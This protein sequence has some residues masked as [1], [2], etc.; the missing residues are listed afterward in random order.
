MALS[1]A[2]ARLKADREIVMGA[3]KQNG[4]ALSYASADLKGDRE[5]VMDAVQQDGR[6]LEYVSADFKGDREIV[7]EAVKHAGWILDYASANLK[8][9]REIV[10][11]AVKQNGYALKYASA[12]LQDDREV[13]LEAVKQNG[14]ALKYASPEL[15]DGG[16]KEYLVEQINSVFNVPTDTIISTILFAAKAASDGS[17]SRLCYKSACA[18]SKLRPSVVMNK[19]LSTFTK[20]LICD[21]AGVRKGSKW[22]LI[23]GAARNLEI[24]T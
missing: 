18:L 9:D 3:V 24:I 20:Q 17:T 21:Y 4:L 16:L 22:K 14:E 12:D 15:R 10:L 2:S 5:F 11:E 19:G 1:Y 13:V 8:G 7:M 23:Q 6:A